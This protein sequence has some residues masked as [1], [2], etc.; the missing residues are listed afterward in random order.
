MSASMNDIKMHLL[1]YDTEIS[2]RAELFLE[3]RYSIHL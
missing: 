3:R 1:L 2:L